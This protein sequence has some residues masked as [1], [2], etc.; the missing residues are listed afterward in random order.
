MLTVCVNNVDTIAKQACTGGLLTDERASNACHRWLIVLLVAAIAAI[1][2]VPSN[3][4]AARPQTDFAVFG[5]HPTGSTGTL[6]L[7]GIAVGAVASLGLCLL[8]AGARRTAPP[9]GRSLNQ[10]RQI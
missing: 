2:G 10:A 5:Y 8:L 3:A 9:D 7:F 6:F 4:G 1:V